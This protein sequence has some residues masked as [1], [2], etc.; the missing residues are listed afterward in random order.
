VQT[1]RAAADHGELG[2]GGQRRNGKTAS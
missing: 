1:G 2:V